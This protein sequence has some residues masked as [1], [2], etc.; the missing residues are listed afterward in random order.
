MTESPCKSCPHTMWHSQLPQ[1]AQEG[2]S[3]IVERK[4]SGAGMLD[5][6]LRDEEA[7]C[8]PPLVT[9]QGPLGFQ[10]SLIPWVIVWVS[11][12]DSAEADGPHG[13][14]PPRGFREQVGKMA[15]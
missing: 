4:G 8:C 11:G 14:S 2:K 15:M 1:L 10:R 5:W 7:E 13:L 12:S 6:S 9:G 3:A